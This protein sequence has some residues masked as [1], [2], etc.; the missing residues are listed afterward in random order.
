MRV[1][2]QYQYLSRPV[3]RALGGAQQPISSTLGSFYVTDYVMHQFMPS[4]LV[5]SWIGSAKGCVDLSYFLPNPIISSIFTLGFGLSV[6]PSRVRRLRGQT[7]MRRSLD[8]LVTHDLALQLKI[9]KAGN[10]A[11]QQVGNSVQMGRCMKD[12]VAM[13]KSEP[14]KLLP[15]FRQFIESI[16]DD[17]TQLIQEDKAEFEQLLSEVACL[18]S[19][20]NA[21][22]YNALMTSMREKLPDFALNQAQERSRSTLDLARSWYHTDLKPLI[23]T[24]I[25]KAGVVFGALALSWYGFVENVSLPQ[26]IDG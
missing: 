8:Q 17:L 10:H 4:A 5:F 18:T 15:N 24:D 26:P 13:I 6:V 23:A 21:E 11:L 1:L 20:F 22:G 3:A 9:R 12:L 25:A 14:D 16:P 2:P 19:S 7:A